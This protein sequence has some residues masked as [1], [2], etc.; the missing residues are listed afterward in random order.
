MG[1]TNVNIKAAKNN[2]IF[3]KTIYFRQT[4]SGNIN[5]WHIINIA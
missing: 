5:N 2:P 3:K 4:E 1:D